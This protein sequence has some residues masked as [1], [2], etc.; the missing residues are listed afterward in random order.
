VAYVEDGFYAFAV[1]V[2]AFD[3]VTS[4]FEVTQD[5]SQ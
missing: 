4:P 3:G 5:T 1:H 2:I